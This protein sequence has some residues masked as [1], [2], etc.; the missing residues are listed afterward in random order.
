MRKHVVPSRK[1]LLPGRSQVV[2]NRINQPPR[3]IHLSRDRANPSLSRKRL[4]YSTPTLDQILQILS[5]RLFGKRPF[6]NEP[7][8]VS[9]LDRCRFLCNFRPRTG[10]KLNFDYMLENN[11][12]FDLILGFSIKAPVRRPSC[13]SDQHVREVAVTKDSGPFSIRDIGREMMLST[14]SFLPY[15]MKGSTC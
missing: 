8:K 13:V 10:V 4:A 3:G 6:P 9:G 2:P 11:A 15:G 5:R 7:M 12:F 1:H 14:I